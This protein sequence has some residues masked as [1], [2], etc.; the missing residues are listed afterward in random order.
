MTGAVNDNR[1]RRPRLSELK[2]TLK[3]L[4]ENG[5]KPCA[6]D[7]LPD[8]T[9]RWHFTEPPAGDETV[10]DRELAEFEAKHGYGRA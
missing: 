6:L 3:V 8:G 7:R 10:L 5:L 9:I 1:R 4:Q 2:G